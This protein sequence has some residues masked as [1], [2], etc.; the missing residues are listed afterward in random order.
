MNL[1]LIACKVL[2]RELSYL[3]AQSPNFIDASYLRQG[4]HNTPEK[5][6][7]IL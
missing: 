4:L 5:L 6:R 7:D 2:C 1:K 3:T